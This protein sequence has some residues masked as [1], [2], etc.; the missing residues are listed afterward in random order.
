MHLAVPR[1]LLVC[2]RLKL[3][4]E[5]WYDGISITPIETVFVP[6]DLV[7]STNQWSYV[8]TVRKYDQW[9]KAQVR[10]PPKTGN[11]KPR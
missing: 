11:R 8:K 6:I 5:S 3:T 1:V 7:A 2:P 9:L 4:G 10:A